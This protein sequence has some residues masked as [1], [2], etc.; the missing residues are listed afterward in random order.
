MVLVVRVG[1]DVLA[2]GRVMEGEDSRHQAQAFWRLGGCLTAGR[3]VDGHLRAQERAVGEGRAVG[4]WAS[5]YVHSASGGG[6]GGTRLPSPE[7]D[8]E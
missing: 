2:D 1:I 4:E 7:V 5:A 6:G 8:L 3:G